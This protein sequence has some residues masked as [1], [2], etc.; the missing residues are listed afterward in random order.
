[1]VKIKSK[2]RVRKHSYEIINELIYRVKLN[3][4]GSRSDFGDLDS[5]STSA[6]SNLLS[7]LQSAK[8]VLTGNCIKQENFSTR[9]KELCDVI[10]L[11]DRLSEA[12]V[13]SVHNNI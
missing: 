7:A 2:I 13:I 3:L 4:L 5:K 12:K 11:I 1:M 6:L 8:T 10:D 9:S